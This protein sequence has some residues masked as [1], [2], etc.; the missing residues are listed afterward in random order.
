MAKSVIVENALNGE[1]REIT[2]DVMFVITNG[3]LTKKIVN[4]KRRG[5]RKHKKT[6][7]SISHSSPITSKDLYGFIKLRRY[8]KCGAYSDTKTWK[9]N[10]SI[11]KQW[12]RHPRRLV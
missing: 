8:W 6:I 4:R 5:K 3:K 12:Q 11:S 2:L 1:I 9:N 10:K 7:I